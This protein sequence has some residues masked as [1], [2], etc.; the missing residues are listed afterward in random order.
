MQRDSRFQTLRSYEPLFST[1]PIP[2]SES[3]FDHILK[4]QFAPVFE[5][6]FEPCKVEIST[7][8]AAESA[9]PYSRRERD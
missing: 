3:S 2:E 5:L 4:P 1:I 8:F 6:E 7:K 9:C